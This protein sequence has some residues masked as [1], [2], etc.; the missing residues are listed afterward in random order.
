MTRAEKRRERA[1]GTL[2]I[3]RVDPSRLTD[4]SMQ[5]GSTDLGEGQRR[6][7]KTLSLSKKDC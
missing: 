4:L 6:T 7:E 3:W 5:L 1:S 2:P